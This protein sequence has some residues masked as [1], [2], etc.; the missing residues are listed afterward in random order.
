MPV[1]LITG[2]DDS[3]IAE[4][5]KKLVHQIGD[6]DPFSFEVYEENEEK[7]AAQVVAEVIASIMTPSM[8]GGAKTVWLRN[9]EA[10]AGT[11][12]PEA[13]TG[14]VKRLAEIIS[15]EF[16]P[17]VTLVIDGPG[18]AQ[19]QLLAACKAAGKVEIH[20]RP[21][22]TSR[23]W[24]REVAHLIGQACGQR[25]MV[26]A[27]ES[28]DYLLEVIGVQTGRVQGEIEKI[29]CYAGA[30]PTL[31]QVQDVCTGNREAVYY[32]LSNAFGDRDL[33]AAYDAIMQLMANHKNPE[34]CAI[35]LIR[36][37]AKF[38]HQLLEAKLLCGTLKVR[39]PQQLAGAIEKMTPEHEALFK[40][41][42][43]R[44][45]SDW[46][47]NK[48]AG[49]AARYSGPELVGAVAILAE[50]DR[51]NVSSSLPRRLVLEAL[52]ARVISPAR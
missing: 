10:L 8:F 23:N 14:N 36:Q 51:Y 41:Y 13:L 12:L 50:A 26:L 15:D 3:T 40:H 21:E 47:I 31:A 20:K 44:E 43:L 22:I 46:L 25:G 35:G 18:I 7:A 45:K 52:A 1:Y 27:P 34:S 4:A 11:P 39:R 38:F 29:F 49:Q 42:G 32:A 2:S 16:P 48:T 9:F 33:Q 24:R 30:G 28:I 37:A 5:A 19:K 17:D 6:D